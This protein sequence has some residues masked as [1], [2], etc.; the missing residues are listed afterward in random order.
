[1][2]NKNKDLDLAYSFWQ[3][4]RYLQ[5][6]GGVIGTVYICDALSIAYNKSFIT[7][8]QY[9]LSTRLI[10]NR[11]DGEDTLESWLEMKHGVVIN[12][13]MIKTYEIKLQTTRHEWL[14]SLIEEFS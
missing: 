5:Q 7:E 10:K 14:N 2:K 11:L 13:S 8:S 12:Q 6:P 4:K 9:L 1:M 3:A